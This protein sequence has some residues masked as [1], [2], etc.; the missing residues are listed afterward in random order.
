ML[1]IMVANDDFLNEPP[2]YMT[3]EDGDYIEEVV[4]ITIIHLQNV[5]IKH[6]VTRT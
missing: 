1:V 6:L 2:I 3:G 5:T 4:E